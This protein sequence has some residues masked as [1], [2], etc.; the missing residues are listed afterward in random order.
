MRHPGPS[1]YTRAEARFLPGV[2]LAGRCRIV[3]LLGRGGMGEVYRADDLKLGRPVAL[4]FLPPGF[5]ANPD[6][7]QLDCAPNDATAF[8]RPGEI[9]SVTFPA[10]SSI[11]W[12]PAGQIAGAGTVYDVMRGALAQLPVGKAPGETCLVQS[13]PDASLSVGSGPPAG[14]GFYYLVRGGNACG[15]GSYGF[16][17]SGRD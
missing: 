7:L 14:T 1:R 6:L 10:E 2:V 16:E 12:A 8:A 15:V 11:A 9:R 4:K 17:T 3:G 13:T 5:D